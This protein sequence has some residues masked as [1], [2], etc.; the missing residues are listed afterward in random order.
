M[1][2]KAVFTL[3]G[4]FLTVAI[5]VPIIIFSLQAQDDLIIIQN[6]TGMQTS[7]NLTATPPSPDQILASHQIILLIVVIIDVVFVLLF[8]VTLYQGIKHVH[9]TH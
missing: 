9:P 5:V 3:A 6:P 2:N 7:G 1:H 8:I 4:V